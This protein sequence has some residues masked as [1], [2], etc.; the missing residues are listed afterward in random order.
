M[1]CQ[2]HDGPGAVGLD[3]PDP[4]GL[5]VRS[6]NDSSGIELNTRYPAGMPFKGS[7]VALAFNWKKIISLMS[8]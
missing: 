7:D 8:G 2:G 4:D 3:V 6:R 1:P 5:V